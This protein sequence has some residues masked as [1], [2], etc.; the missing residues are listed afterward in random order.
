MSERADIQ[1]WKWKRG[2]NSQQQVSSQIIGVRGIKRAEV[3]R[4]VTRHAM[5]AEYKY[6][7]WH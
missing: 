7:M 6:C 2:V 5:Q 1:H 3:H 4:P